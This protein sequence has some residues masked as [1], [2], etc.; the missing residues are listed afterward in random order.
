MSE[1]SSKYTAAI[2]R[3]TEMA[4]YMRYGNYGRYADIVKKYESIKYVNTP[5]HPHILRLKIGSEYMPAFVMNKPI[6][7]T[8]PQQEAERYYTEVGKILGVQ[9]IQEVVANT[10]SGKKLSAEQ[11]A[12]GWGHSI[13]GLTQGDGACA[14]TNISILHFLGEHIAG[15]F[16]NG[17]LVK[18]AAHR[19]LHRGNHIFTE[20]ANSDLIH[21]IV[22][23]NIR[24][25][26]AQLA[27]KLNS[28]GAT[29]SENGS[30][31]SI[32]AL[33]NDPSII[34]YL[35]AAS[36]WI[37]WRVFDKRMIEALDIFRTKMGVVGG[38]TSNPAT[39]RGF[40]DEKRGKH[41]RIISHVPDVGYPR[42]ANGMFSA[43]QMVE[44]V[45]KGSPMAVPDDATKYVLA[46]FYGITD[47]FV[48]GDNVGQLVDHEKVLQKWKSTAHDRFILGSTSGNGA[49]IDELEEMVDNFQKYKHKNKQSP[50]TCAIFIGN[51]KEGLIDIRMNGLINK[52]REAGAVEVTGSW[53]KPFE[54][55]KEEVLKAK[56]KLMLIR[57]EDIELVSITKQWL[58][59]IAHVEA[60]KPGEAHFIN[61]HV[62]TVSCL[63]TPA[64]PNEPYNGIVALR[65]GGSIARSKEWPNYLKAYFRTI[66][67]KDEDIEKEIASIPGIS[68][69]KDNI[70][71]SLDAQWDTVQKQAMMGFVE[72]SN[73]TVPLLAMELATVLEKPLTGE[74]GQEVRDNITRFLKEERERKKNLVQN[75]FP[76]IAVKIFPEIAE[77]NDPFDKKKQTESLLLY[78]FIFVLGIITGILAK[79]AINSMTEHS[80][81]LK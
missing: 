53:D 60:V 44:F 64:P 27:F 56:G 68:N 26:I 2:R 13:E 30:L 45:N 48:V 14:I 21:S 24:A 34:R 22:K 75:M 20:I 12:A 4:D 40:L 8:L 43:S 33:A 7:S 6:L 49:N 52:A 59:Q 10:M 51:H 5:F 78:L 25:R 62:G 31:N 65:K 9:H 54:K 47:S 79:P 72:V 29:T 11:T 15:E 35:L 37:N 16:G 74:H 61:P 32:N 36:Y 69:R 23:D 41:H 67:W 63:L 71:E 18:E 76:E 39:E 81:R 77:V 3:R 80:K 57:A 73:A 66:G 58:E 38:Y 70:F 42:K 46:H 55:F 50:Y 19:A 17:Y 28:L 1:Q